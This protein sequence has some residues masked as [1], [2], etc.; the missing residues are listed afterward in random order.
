MRVDE[1]V[2]AAFV[3]TL[4]VI[5]VRLSTASAP[6]RRPGGAQ[7]PPPKPPSYPLI[8]IGTFFIVCIMLRAF[9]GG[10]QVGGAG[11]GPVADLD[12]EEVLKYMDNDGPLF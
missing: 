10:A 1:V 9:R 4:V 3:S 8:F 12:L 11:A 2:Q 6:A 5:V 7:G